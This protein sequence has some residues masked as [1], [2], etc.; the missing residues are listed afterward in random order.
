MGCSAL[1]NYHFQMGVTV[2]GFVGHFGPGHICSQLQPAYVANYFLGE[3]TYTN[4]QNCEILM[5]ANFKNIKGF[6]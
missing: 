2:M 3:K 1:P 6:Y 4:K 5:K